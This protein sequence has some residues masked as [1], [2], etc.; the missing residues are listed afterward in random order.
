MRRVYGDKGHLS[1][2]MNSS[3]QQ[4]LISLC[5]FSARLLLSLEAVAVL[6]WEKDSTMHIT[7]DENDI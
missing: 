3:T 5:L 6:S 4:T 7:F 1:G 2:R